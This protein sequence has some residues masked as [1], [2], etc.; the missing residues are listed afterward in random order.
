MGEC[1][2]PGETV[3]NGVRVRRFSV[4]QTRKLGPFADL[5][6][7]VFDGV[8]PP[9][10][11]QHWFAENGPDVP[12]LLEHLRA[13][14]SDYDLVLF[15]TF[16]YSPSFFGVPLVAIA[17]CWCPRPKRIA[18]STSTCCRTSSGCPPG[19]SS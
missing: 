9:E 7:E 8:T 2:S 4:R 17:P 11:Q 5:S 18:R 19:T 6:D 3:E 1:V 10:R 16:R 13:H 14:G 15:W 12:E